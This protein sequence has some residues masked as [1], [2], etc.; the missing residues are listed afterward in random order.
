MRRGA[1]VG[2]WAVVAAVILGGCSDGGNG[3]AQSDQPDTAG[4]T[5]GRTIFV[6]QCSSCHALADA[7]A[8]G[9]FGPN[10]DQGDYDAEGVERKVRA[11]GGG[12]PSFEDRLTDEQI[13][14][15]SEYV[16]S[17]SAD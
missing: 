4:P 7:D 9:T 15:V 5:D 6:Q 10:L 1:L 17:A 16:A 13:R 2:T 8:T 11:G 12:M 14:A 3:S